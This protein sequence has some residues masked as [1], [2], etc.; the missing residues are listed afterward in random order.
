[1]KDAKD[2]LEE[3]IIEDECKN[4]P[5]KEEIEIK[6]KKKIADEIEKKKRVELHKKRMKEV[7]PVIIKDT[8]F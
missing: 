7:P 4:P 3:F 2:R 1:M 8:D 6:R 5:T